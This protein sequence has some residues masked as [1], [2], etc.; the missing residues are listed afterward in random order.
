MAPPRE[1]EPHPSHTGEGAFRWIGRRVPGFHGAVGSVLALGFG[2]AA[3]AAVLFGALARWMRT[4]G[5]RSWD[6]A[7]MRWLAARHTTRLDFMM[8][9]IT[10]L[11][12]V[13]VVGIVTLVAATFLW[14]TRHRYS[15]ALLVVAAAGGGALNYLLKAAFERPRPELFEWLTHAGHTSF[16]S[17]H[18]TNAMVV[19]GTLAF[20]VARLEPTRAMRVFTWGVAALLIVLIGVSRPYLGVHY[21]SDVLAGYAV[22]LSWVM[23]CAATLEAVRH[24]RRRR[25]EVTRVERNLERSRAGE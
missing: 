11:G 14:L 17:G 19:Y 25:P 2:L 23:A 4:G 16:P 9:E 21:P 24:F 12:S 15:A 6:E 18:A 5:A 7:V 1:P 3:V 20:L 8:M 13:T 22:G 10:A